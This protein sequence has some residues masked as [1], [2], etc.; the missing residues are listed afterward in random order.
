MNGAQQLSVNG[1]QN[2]SVNGSISVTA[3]AQMSFVCGASSIVM[4][5]GG[6]ITISG[7][8][9]SIVGSATLVTEAPL[10]NIKC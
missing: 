2:V 9:V 10:T 3:T 6:T 4:D 5:S 1:A 7:V 8:N